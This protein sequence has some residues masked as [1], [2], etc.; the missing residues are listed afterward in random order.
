[1]SL[2]LLIRSWCLVTVSVLSLCWS[3]IPHCW[4]SHVEAHLFR[5]LCVTFNSSSVL[6]YLTKAVIMF[7]LIPFF[8]V[9]SIVWCGS[10]FGPCFVMQ[11]VLSVLVLQSSWWG[12]ESWLLYFNCLPDVALS[13]LWLF[14][15]VPWVGLQ[16]VIVVF[17]DHTHL[18]F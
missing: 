8:M 3:Y 14:L 10:V 13:V 4:K 11:N 15:T 9:A 17:P 18:L 1:M 12:R 6:S 16:C 7:L 5:G 2:L